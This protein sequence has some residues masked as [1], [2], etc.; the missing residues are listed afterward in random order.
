MIC[1]SLA[2]GIPTRNALYAAAISERSGALKI[3]SNLNRADV[4]EAHAVDDGFIRDQAE[5]A[6]FG[7]AGLSF[8]CYGTDFNG[9]ETQSAEGCDMLAVLIHACS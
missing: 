2:T 5:E 4:V 3:L 8:R 7:I 9:T 1:R 6:G